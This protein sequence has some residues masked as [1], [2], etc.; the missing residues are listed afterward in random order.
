[1]DS[2]LRIVSLDYSHGLDV[3][4]VPLAPLGGTREF[5]LSWLPQPVPFGEELKQHKLFALQHMSA[6]LQGAGASGPAP[7]P[8]AP[9]GA[10]FESAVWC[11]G[12]GSVAVGERVNVGMGGGVRDDFIASRVVWLAHCQCAL[13]ACNYF[14]L[15]GTGGGESGMPSGCELRLI[16][17]TQGAEHVVEAMFLGREERVHCLTLVTSRDGELLVCVGTG[18]FALVS[19]RTRMHS[20]SAHA[21]ARM[22]FHTPAS[23]GDDRV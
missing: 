4:T 23:Q 9:D 19:S 17:M 11:K 10:D 15:K 20:H 16:D 8:P 21:H 22:R 7:I 5:A 14:G 12:A 13:V 2:Q 1:V 3:T 18:W 6:G